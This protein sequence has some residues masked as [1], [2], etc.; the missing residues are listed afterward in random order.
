MGGCFLCVSVTMETLGGSRLEWGVARWLAELISVKAT[1]KFLALT[2][3][4]S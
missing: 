4:I 2:R 1:Y 3:Q